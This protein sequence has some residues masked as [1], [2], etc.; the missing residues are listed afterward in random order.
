MWRRIWRSIRAGGPYLHDL[1]DCEVKHGVRIGLANLYDS[2]IGN[3]QLPKKLQ[4]VRKHRTHVRWAAV[5]IGLVVV[6]ALAAAVS[7]FFAQSTGAF[8]RHC[9][10]KKHRGASV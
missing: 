3:A 10:G 2:E 4:A 5:A 7:L 8:A 9:R 6:A 1:G